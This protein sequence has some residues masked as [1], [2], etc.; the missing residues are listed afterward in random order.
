MIAATPDIAVEARI[1]T[2]GMKSTIEPEKDAR[3]TH[4]EIAK[5]MPFTCNGRRCPYLSLQSLSLRARQWTATWE[6]Q[7]AGQ[8]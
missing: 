4:P 3:I 6:G 8:E 7:I 2:A 1:A 5:Y